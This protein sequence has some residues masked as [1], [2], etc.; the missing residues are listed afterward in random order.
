MA[1]TSKKYEKFYETTG[2]GADKID[3]KKLTNVTNAWAGEK[4]EGCQKYLDD[5]VMAPLIY[6]LQQM[7]D[8]LDYLRTEISSNKDNKITIGTNTT[9]SFGDLTETTV[10]GTTTYSI[11]LTATRNF[12]G[13][14]GSQTKSIT[15]TLT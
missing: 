6:Q 8:E 5:P 11:T 1:L 10:K 2:S 15:L 12:G 4:A 7:Q 14:T 3:D 13:K 9:L